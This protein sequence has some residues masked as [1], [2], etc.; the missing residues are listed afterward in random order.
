MSPRKAVTFNA[1]AVR[2]EGL[3]DFVSALKAVD[4]QYP[5]AVRQANYDMA[6]E[7]VARSKADAA[8]VGGVARKAA[9]SLRAARQA[10]AS[11]VT[12]GGAR[13]PYFWGAEFGARQYR[14][15][16]PWRGNQYGG[17]SGGPGYFLHPTIRSEAE[18]LLDGYMAR[19]DA[20]AG[21]AFPD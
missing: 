19:L 17:W 1:D 16:K 5:K 11:V 20:L 10:N 6:A 13:Y 7:L 8:S 12:G 14:Q 3:R 9:R 21:E 4:A 2:I 15:F 18:R